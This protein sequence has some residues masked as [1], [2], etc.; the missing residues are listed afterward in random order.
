MKEKSPIIEV[1]RKTMPAVVSVVISKSIKALEAEIAKEAPN[2]LPLGNEKME[3][4]K[5]AIDAHGM[6]KIGGGSGFIVDKSGII[7]TNKHV[8]AD[9]E[10]EYTIFLYS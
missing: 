10:A 7:L 5:E 9:A 3:I 4:P 1:I 8:I 2:V 6:V